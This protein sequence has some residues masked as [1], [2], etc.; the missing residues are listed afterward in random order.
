MGS[1]RTS[2]ALWHLVVEVM[3]LR[4]EV[5]VGGDMLAVSTGAGSDPSDV[6]SDEPTSGFV[7]SFSLVEEDTEVAA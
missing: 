3:E 5:I 1:I 6:T 4:E 2:L 7:E